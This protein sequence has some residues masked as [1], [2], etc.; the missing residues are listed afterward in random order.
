V[1]E[2]FAWLGEGEHGGEDAPQLDRQYAVLRNEPHLFDQRADGLG[3]VFASAFA[4]EGLMKGGD[5]PAVMLG[6]VRV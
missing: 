5:L 6:E 3:R 4:G 1:A 2:V